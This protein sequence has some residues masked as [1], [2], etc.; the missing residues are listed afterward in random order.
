M[1]ISCGVGLLKV[2]VMKSP[3]LEFHWWSWLMRVALQAWSE[4]DVLK[5]SPKLNSG[6]TGFRDSVKRDIRAFLASTT[7][8]NGECPE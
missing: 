3:S 5:L 1:C 4:N 7:L 6:G 8:E 2:S